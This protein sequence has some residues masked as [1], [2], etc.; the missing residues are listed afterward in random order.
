[1]TSGSRMDQVDAQ[2]TDT[3]VP[4]LEESK[5]LKNEQ[6]TP[7]T[8]HLKVL[9]LLNLKKG[10]SKGD[11]PAANLHTFRKLV[12]LEF[13]GS[14]FII[15]LGLLAAIMEGAVL[16]SFAIIFGKNFNLFTES[17]SAIQSTTWK[18]SLA[19]FALGVGVNILAY[20]RVST[21]G[22]ASEKLSKN[23]RTAAFS[24]LVRQEV[25]YHDIQKSGELANRLSSD[26]SLIQTG[27]AKA[28]Q[29]I[30]NISQCV[31]GVIIGLA[32]GPALAGVLIALSP[33]I[34][35]SGAIEMMQL[36]GSVKKGSEAYNVAGSVVSETLSNIR[37]TKAFCAEDYEASRYEERL[38]PVYKTGVVKYNK[39]GLFLGFSMLTIFSVYALAFWW[40]GTL[41][42]RHSLNSGDMLT[43]FFS[44]VIGFVGLGQAAQV[45]PDVTKGISASETLFEIISRKPTY[46]KFL[47]VEKQQLQLEHSI[48]FE[49]V[50]FA[51]PTRPDAI[52]L[53]DF[54]I[55]IPAG[56]TVALV[57]PSGSGKSTVVSLLAR[58]YDVE[59][60]H[61]EIRIDGRSIFEYSPEQIRANIGLVSQE[62]VLFSGTIEENI[63]YGNRNA[64]REQ[65]EAAAKASNAHHFIMSL[66]DKYQ[67]QVGDRGIQL[68]GGQKQRIAIA[69]AILKDP[70]LLLL[71]EAT[72]ALDAE[73]ESLVQEA[74]D[75]LMEDS[76]R[77][78][79]VI[80]HRL[81]TVRNAYL[82]AVL[83]NGVLVEIGNHD[84]LMSKEDGIYRNLVHRQLIVDWSTMRLVIRSRSGKQ[85][86]EVQIEESLTVY[87]LKEKI[88]DKIPQLIPSRQRLSIETKDSKRT[89]LDETQSLK[90][91]PLQDNSI[92]YLKDLGLQVSWKLVF[93]LEYLGPLLIVSLLS[94]Q[95]TAIYPSKVLGREQKVAVM[96]WLF[97]FGK[98][99]LETLFVHR[100][101]HSTM[102]WKNLVKNCSY[103]WGFAALI[104]YF[105]CH[106]LYTP[107]PSPLFYLGICIF[108]LAECGN[109]ATHWMLRQL[110]SSSG[111][112]TRKI[113]RGFLF[114]YVSCPNY[115][116]EIVAWLG[117]NMMSNTLLGWLFMFVGAIQMTL[118]AQKKH[119]QY[120][121]EFNGSH[122]KPLYPS[123]RKRIFPLLY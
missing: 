25:S 35:L 119:R 83:E 2:P 123:Q 59:P 50:S 97:H 102:P 29:Y 76:K 70:K 12:A 93:F 49:H 75:R 81:T 98:R 6:N 121:L 3:I 71:D 94:L 92:V 18:Y 65:V 48:Q 73:S 87:Q 8:W 118:W 114:E 54:S 61:G 23:L 42:A 90:S 53:K 89:V 106:P 40:G 27:L 55:D 5:N 56:K 111:S 101:S 91:Y 100:F 79:V 11:K 10:T 72:S 22:V 7:E 26:V 77:T 34:A 16:P 32:F 60:Y 17:S 110:R 85:L 62:P 43:V 66:P 84:T 44:V 31:V 28:G 19:F 33:L 105:L 103:Y 13:R 78:T 64:T 57:G 63:L 108:V 69:R 30:M 21:F 9:R 109:F 37:T 82:I 116:L 99:E 36:S 51:Y 117:F 52:I 107:V 14:P 39:E 86:C 96:L 95:P 74:L 38:V 88:T 4:V 45:W 104:G 15:C 80:A 113:P 112:K 47:S 1:M 68:S 20:I 67:T 41:I 120:L 46:R 115:T 122:S 24:S 58:F